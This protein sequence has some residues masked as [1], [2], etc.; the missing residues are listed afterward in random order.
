MDFQMEH[1]YD[2]QNTC[3]HVTLSG[4]IDIFNSAALK[5]RLSELLAQHNAHLYLYCKHLEFIDSTGLGALVAV[6]KN[7]KSNNK[8]MH[9]ISVKPGL[10]KLFKITNLDTV[11]IMREEENA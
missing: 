1:K 9:L 8:D 11:F 2:E 10:K 7:I 5:S 3:W 4:E 6:L